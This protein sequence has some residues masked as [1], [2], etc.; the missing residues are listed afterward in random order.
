VGGDS[1]R[2]ALVG[3]VTPAASAK[4]ELW[5]VPLTAMGRAVRDAEVVVSS[6]EPRDGLG[7]PLRMFH[8][9][10]LQEAG[11]RCHDA[12][13][14]LEAIRLAAIP[15]EEGRV[16]LATGKYLGEGFDDP[17]LDTLFLTD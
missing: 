7:I 15:P 3:D 6:S 5:Q 11:A 14:F 4:A 1:R 17:R 2:T 8:E 13:G 12:N 16:I 10:D 9:A